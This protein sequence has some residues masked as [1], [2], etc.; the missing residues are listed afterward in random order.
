VL[1]FAERV[2]G[3]A[4]G[5]GREATRAGLLGRQWLSRPHR[6]RRGT[7]E[8]VVGVGGECRGV[9]WAETY[10]VES[11]RR[12]GDRTDEDREECC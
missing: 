3:D 11:Q 5:C 10:R 9:V 6:R 12:G 2:D 1:R 4:L 8:G 7:R